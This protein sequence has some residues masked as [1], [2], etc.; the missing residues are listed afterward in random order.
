MRARFDGLDPQRAAEVI[1]TPATG[2]D[3]RGSGYLLAG[4]LVLT[5]A[6]VVDGAT[7]IRVR[8]NADQEGQWIARAHPAWSDTGLDIAVLRIIE[9]S[10][11]PL[12]AAP[13]VA[14][15]RFGR[16]TRPPVECETVGFPRFKVREDP[17]HLGAD[18]RPTQYRDSEHAIGPATTWSNRREGTLQIRVGK[19]EHGSDRRRSP[20][21]GMSGAPVFSGDA[22][23]GVIGK[24]HRSDGLGTLA[25]Y[26]ID[27]WHERLD[28]DQIAWLAARIG[29][30]ATSEGLTQVTA[31]TQVQAGGPPRQ[32]PA[33][34]PAFTGREDELAELLSLAAGTGGGG[35]PG[36]V[37][38]SAIDG[39]AGIGKT[40][41]AV[42]AGHAL[43]LR[44]PDGQLFIDLRGY[45]QG[46]TP[47]DP[48]DAL[49]A[50]LQAYEVPPGQIPADLDARAAFYRDRLAGTRTLIILDNAYSEAQVR[51]LLPGDGGCLVVV[52]SRRRLKALDD[53]H[54]LPLDVLPAADAVALFRQVAGPG[55]IPADDPLLEEIATLCGRLPL[56]LRI[57]AA[58]IRHRPAWTLARL[59]DKLRQARPGLEGFSDGERNLTCVFDLSYR[60][61]GDDRRL[62][63]RRLGLAPGPDADAYAA[64]ALLDCGPT[65]AEDLLQDLVD[66]N[67]LAELAAC[68]YRM[69]DLVRAY[70]LAAHDPAERRK[71]ALDR[72]LDY[73]QHTAARADA[74]IAHYSKPEPVGPA[75]AH[76]P[77]LPNPD[78][79]RG[80]LRAERANLEASLRH[81]A[82]H[83]QNARL[84]ALSAGLASLL[85]TDGPWPLALSVH[86]AATAAAARLGDRPGQA[87]ALTNLGQ[88]RGLTADYPGASRDLQQ[89]LGLYRGSG[90]RSGQAN[91]LIELGDVWSMT[92]DYPGAE[93]DLLE[94]LE[95]HRETGD[96]RGQAHALNKRGQVRSMTGDFPGAFQ[97]LLEALELHREIGDRRGQAHTLTRLGRVW[98]I[99]GD[100]QGAM[101]DMQEALEL[102]RGLGERLGQA[103]ALTYLGQVRL[104]TGDYSGAMQDLRQ[105]LELYRGLGDRLGQANA[106]AYLGQVWLITGD[107][108]G[109][110]RDIQEA[111][112]LY[113]EIGSRVGEAY[114]LNHY[115]AVLAATG[116]VAQAKAIYRDALRMT[117]EVQQPDDEALALEGIGECLLRE[118]AADEGVHHLRQALATFQRLGMPPDIERVQARLDAP[119]TS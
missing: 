30:P 78:A 33:T 89:A 117:R 67:L 83:N 17:A 50:I 46:V 45:T 20:W 95:L 24:H 110:I 55:R 52:T 119:T 75:P 115:A 35:S 8:F 74:H 3:R 28:A 80:W 49:A 87:S 9:E 113:R 103:N 79:A 56:A 36:T 76:A 111:L 63:F 84:V 34:T 96:R 18:R 81:A 14:G 99:T 21:E 59:A 73:Y 12:G 69:H 108:Q 85:S 91:A 15:V 22:L 2:R 93:R 101:R 105:A 48:L 5:A 26:R 43:A 82:D 10:V 71:T 72:L 66:H 112:E 44:F 104:S 92:G 86:T 6:H 31:P 61:L 51:P 1:T 37:V 53:A 102:Y 40:A 114:A 58:L 38:I 109:A 98:L 39:M 19:P 4:G 16:I 118:G 11:D 65:K 47:R 41:L 90:D 32:L 64:A 68:R 29:L 7:T 94:G 60:A 42:K 70:A 100:H 13:V 62:L 116:Q 57:A 97:D 106:L 77:A 23:I 27:H 88:V 54:A 25:A 107:H